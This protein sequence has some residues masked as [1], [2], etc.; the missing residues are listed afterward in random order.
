[1]VTVL[2]SPSLGSPVYFFLTY[3]PLIDAVYSTIF[4]PKLLMD[5]LSDRKTI[6]FSACMIQ[7]FIEHLFAAAEVFLLVAMAYDCCVAICKPLHYLTIMN[8]CVCILF[9]IVS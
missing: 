5:L 8:R 7:L 9:L 1:M 2:V 6:S 3:L 4:S